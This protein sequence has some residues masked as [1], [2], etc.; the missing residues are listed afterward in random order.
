M[1]N[2]LPLTRL[3]LRESSNT[4]IRLPRKRKKAIFI[5]LMMTDE[6]VLNGS[7]QLRLSVLAVP[8][9]STKCS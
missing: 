3:I 4:E 6:D 9:A 8:D 7:V 2:N 5:K 1:N